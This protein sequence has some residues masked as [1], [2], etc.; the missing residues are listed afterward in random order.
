M[1]TGLF[2]SSRRLDPSTPKQKLPPRQSRLAKSRNAS[3]P[4]AKHDSR[5]SEG[6]IRGKYQSS[7]GIIN[8]HLFVHFCLPVLIQNVWPFL[9]IDP[10]VSRV[11][12]VLAFLGGFRS[13]NV[14]V[15][16]LGQVSLCLQNPDASLAVLTLVANLKLDN[17]SFKCASSGDTI[18]NINVFELPP[19]E[20]LNR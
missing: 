13:A 14:S 15:V 12:G 2:V 16:Y 8:A 18:T 4:C 10:W 20:Y 19:S 7:H 17:V 9:L 1:D 6:N 5:K 3:L 11:T